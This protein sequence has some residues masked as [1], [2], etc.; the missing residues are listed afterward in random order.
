MTSVNKEFMHNQMQIDKLIP[1]RPTQSQ[2]QSLNYQSV[3]QLVPPEGNSTSQYGLKFTLDKRHS[4]AD[5]SSLTG[6][7]HR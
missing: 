3:S 4:T 6:V 2:S 5:A 7:P 1:L